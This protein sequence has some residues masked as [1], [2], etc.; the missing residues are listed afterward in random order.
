MNPYGNTQWFT[1]LIVD[2]STR[3][4]LN[5]QACEAQATQLLRYRLHCPFK[6]SLHLRPYTFCNNKM[7]CDQL[8][9][10][11]ENILQKELHLLSE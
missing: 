7:V 5:S 1:F 10:Y 9:L 6:G 2:M 11:L 8:F 3:N 4:S